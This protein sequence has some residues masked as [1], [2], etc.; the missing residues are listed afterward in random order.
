[1]KKKTAKEQFMEM[2]MKE[3]KDKGIRGKEVSHK[4]TVAVML[5][6]AKRKGFKV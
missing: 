6:D 2:K 4:Q 5:S 1:M 3:I